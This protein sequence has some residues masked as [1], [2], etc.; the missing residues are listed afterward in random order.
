MTD[1]MIPSVDRCMSFTAPSLPIPTT[2]S[3]GELETS[4]VLSMLDDSS[5]T[6]EVLWTHFVLR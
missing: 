3:N 5:T 1:K 4:V 2:S 6:I